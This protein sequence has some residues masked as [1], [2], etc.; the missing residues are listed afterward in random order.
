MS[1]PGSPGSPGSSG[2][3]SG[4]RSPTR[5]QP[6]GPF[7]FADFSPK[8]SRPSNASA[9]AASPSRGDRL[10]S[11]AL[12]LSVVRQEAS[13][14]NAGGASSPGSPSDAAVD[15]R[16]V[17][18][19]RSSYEPY[20]R[21][22][23]RSKGA[24]SDVCTEDYVKHV[25]V[26]RSC[27]PARCDK[28]SSLR[29]ILR[30][31]AGHSSAEHQIIPVSRLSDVKTSEDATFYN[32][33]A[34]KLTEPS[35]RVGGRRAYPHGAGLPSGGT[36]GG[37]LAPGAMEVG[38]GSMSRSASEN[39]LV[40]GLRSGAA[41]HRS[42]NFEQRCRFWDGRQIR[43]QFDNNPS[44]RVGVL[45]SSSEAGDGG[46]LPPTSPQ[47][48]R[49]LGSAPVS[50]GRQPVRSGASDSSKLYSGRAGSVTAD[51]ATPRPA[52][53]R[54]VSSARDTSIQNI[55]AHSDAGGSDNAVSS[56]SGR[57]ERAPDWRGTN[58]PMRSAAL[59]AHTTSP[60]E[61]YNFSREHHHN[62][63]RQAQALPRHYAGDHGHHGHFEHHSPGSH[64]SHHSAHSDGRAF[65][66]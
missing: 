8:P 66:A 9:F 53:K 26:S 36:I 33:L 3:A 64:A 52:G 16:G 21:H 13:P 11:Q 54:S 43:R 31:F 39:G 15:Y 20:S 24:C 28:D 55:L 56:C 5:P 59:R 44:T 27:S 42:G 45:L 63:V 50:P 65:L 51:P 17:P 10:A 19:V 4:T 47:S 30:P 12:P 6:R 48:V 18:V 61:H 60:R 38:A 25:L 23:T 32:G 57:W 29:G 62:Q 14:N 40:T 22:T 7:A 41:S 35:N 37:M 1:N 49:S 34:G 46:S 58:P 2:G